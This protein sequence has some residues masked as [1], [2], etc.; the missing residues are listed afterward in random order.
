MPSPAIVN[1]G[2]GSFFI[3]NDENRHEVKEL[4]DI[5]RKHDVQYIDSGRAYVCFLLWPSGCLLT[6]S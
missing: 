2:A 4:G 5:L 1:F 6:L 3:Y